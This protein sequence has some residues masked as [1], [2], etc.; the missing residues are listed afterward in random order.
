MHSLVFQHLFL[1]ITALD[2][3]SSIMRLSSKAFTRG[4]KSQFS[5]LHG[6][7][8]KTRSEA[9][10][11]SMFILKTELLSTSLSQKFARIGKH[12]YLDSKKSD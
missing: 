7:T 5:I 4:N 3:L 8:N 12:D 1:N 6:D 10:L 2:N 11:F 9:F